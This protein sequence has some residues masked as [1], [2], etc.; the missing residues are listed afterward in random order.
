MA[1]SDLFGARVLITGGAG[2]IGSHLMD[3]LLLEKA[4]V[5]VLDNMSTG[6][7]EN[8]AHCLDNIQFISGDIRDLE[9]CQRAC[10]GVKYVF[11]QAALGS[12]PRSIKDPSETIS[13]NVAGTTNVFS[14]ARDQGVHRIVYASSSSVYGDSQIL[15]RREGEE[16]RP[17]SPYALS[18]IMNEQLASIFSITYNMQ[19]VGLRYF[20]VYGPRQDPYGPYAAVI[21]QFLKAALEDTPPQI[22]GDGEQTRDFAFVKDVVKVNLLSAVAPKSVS[23]KVYNIGSGKTISINELA[24]KIGKLAG[25]IWKPKYLPPR[26][27]DVKTSLADISALTQA[28]GFKP[29]FNLSNSF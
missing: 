14:A 11:H 6:R 26:Q 19:F 4:K 8:I 21:P 15:P 7:Q 1:I 20:N 23:G 28:L 24:K 3:G 9:T 13:V 22:Y 18:K 2:F 10:Q 25:K 5:R 27:G 12:V 29:N 16:A 17:L